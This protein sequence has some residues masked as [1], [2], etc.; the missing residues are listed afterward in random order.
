MSAAIESYKR[1]GVTRSMV[2]H[3][4]INYFHYPSAYQDTLEHYYIHHWTPAY[5][6]DMIKDGMLLHGNT[7]HLVVYQN[8]TPYQIHKSKD[9]IRLSFRKPLDCFN[10]PAYVIVRLH[11]E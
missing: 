6:D 9:P 11:N 4:A 8:C 1:I 10:I 3:M 5:F 2:H 7:E